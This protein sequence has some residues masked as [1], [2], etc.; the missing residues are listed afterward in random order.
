MHHDRIVVECN[1]DGFTK[2]NLQAICDVG[3]SSK[4]GDQQG[5]IGEKG[6]GFKSVF[7]AAWKVDIQSGDLSFYFKHRNQD[8]GLGMIHP[9]WLKPTEKL[10][11]PLTRM[12][13]WLHEDGGEEQRTSRSET[14]RQQFKDLDSNLLLFMAKLKEIRVSYFDNN[15]N[16]ESSTVFSIRDTGN[17]LVTVTK[18][19]VKGSE[20]KATESQVYYLVKH[21]VGNLEKNENRSYSADEEQTSAYATAKVVLGFPLNADSVPIDQHQKV[22]AFLPMREKG[23]KVRGP[24]C[25]LSKEDSNFFK[26]LIQGDFVTQANR[27][28]IVT[29]SRRN[30]GILSGISD[31]FMKA[32]SE[33]CEHPTLQ[34]DW[35]KFLPDKE[36]YYDTFWTRLIQMIEKGLRKMPVLQPWSHRTMRTISD[37]RQAVTDRL[38]KNGEPLFGGTCLDVLISWKY[39]HA[40]LQR[41]RTYGLNYIS[42]GETLDFVEQDLRLD[43]SRMKSPETDDDWHTRVAHL[44]AKAYGS[45]IES[46]RKR[47]CQLQ[48]LPLQDGRWAAPDTNVIHFS[49]SAGIPIP[50]QTGL[51]LLDAVAE[52]NPQRMELFR[53]LGIKTASVDLVCRMILD[54]FRH[55]NLAILIRV[56][57]LKFIYLTHHL[58]VDPT[59]GRSMVR[60]INHEHHACLPRMTDVYLP[61]EHEFGVHELFGKAGTK[62]MPDDAL[63]LSFLHEIYLQ[64]SP[65]KPHPTA[66]SWRD[67]LYSYAGVRRYV[68][69]VSADQ[70]QKLSKAVYFVMAHHPKKFFGFLRHHWSEGGSEITDSLELQE[71]L[72]DIPV[73]CEGGQMIALKETYLPFPDLKSQCTKFLRGQESFPF[74]FLNTA[75][76]RGTYAQNWSFLVPRF[77]IGLDAD[78]EFYK[79]ILLQIRVTN[80]LEVKDPERINE[81]YKTI[82]GKYAESPL[83]E[84]NKMGL[85]SVPGAQAI[86]VN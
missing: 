17:N 62:D 28:D 51:T 34:Y 43:I 66:D 76:E 64:S 71:S 7:M 69:L 47:V 10:P 25:Q 19:V 5:Y 1:E 67:W 53:H 12:T 8:K 6:I 21:T 36:G 15:G 46:I 54:P 16:Q 65:E 26:F 73:L 44:L 81:L 80:P 57:H 45:K 85:R 42:Y 31:A 20:D 18:S 40:N 23:F 74:L 55:S 63:Q 33:F 38:D 13:L 83:A 84:M 61:D 77:R 9:V 39:G 58:V 41:L 3:K 2:G 27:E 30:I 75:V 37:L 22:F 79:R 56:N 82:Y 4:T 24:I 32:V 11:R 78:M 35:V 50:Q 49:E 68:R 86:L 72:R 52:K 59:I 29:T 70:R 48:L 60:V 14:I